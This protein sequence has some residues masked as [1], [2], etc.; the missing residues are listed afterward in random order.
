MIDLFFVEQCLHLDKIEAYLRPF[1][2]RVFC[3]GYQVWYDKG[4]LKGVM[5]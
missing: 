3:E 4:S 5:A 2:F 1:G